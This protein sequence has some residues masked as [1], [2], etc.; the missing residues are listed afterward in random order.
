MQEKEGENQQRRCYI[1]Q[2]GIGSIR[3]IPEIEAHKEHN[4]PTINIPGSYLHTKNGEYVIM[5]LRESLAKLMDRV[6]PNLCLK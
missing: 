5:L 2:S 6:E 3:I 1:S 4:V